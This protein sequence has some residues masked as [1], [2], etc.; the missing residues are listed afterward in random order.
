[1]LSDRVDI[2]STFGLGHSLEKIGKLDYVI[3]SEAKQSVVERKS[4]L[5]P[6]WIASSSLRDSS[7]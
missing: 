6:Q 1:M 7:Q 2:N 4:V 5:Y 3:A